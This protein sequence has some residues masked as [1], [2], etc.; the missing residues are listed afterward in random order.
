MYFNS[1]MN[2]EDMSY[3]KLFFQSM[4]FPLI[5][6]KFCVRT[7]SETGMPESVKYFCASSCGVTTC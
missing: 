5:V 1:L 2:M 4:L 3:R 6:E 7:N